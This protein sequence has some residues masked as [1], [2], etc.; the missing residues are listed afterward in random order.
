VRRTDLIGGIVLLA[1]SLIMIFV[2]IPAET[3]EGV[4]HGLSPYVYPIA[5]MMGIAI[6]SALLVLQGLR[7]RGEDEPEVPL[8]LRQLAMFGLVAGIVLAGAIG[9]EAAPPAPSSMLRLAEIDWTASSRAI[10]SIAATGARPTRMSPASVVTSK[11]ASSTWPAG[12][13]SRGACDGS[14]AT[15]RTA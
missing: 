11:P 7:R 10:A 8:S 15:G 2:V 6:A 14:I 9:T 1:F 12:G 13:A 4:W 3:A 5:M